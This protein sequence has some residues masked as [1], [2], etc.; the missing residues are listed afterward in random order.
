[1]LKP[2]VVASV[3]MIACKK[4]KK[5]SAANNK[6]FRLAQTSIPIRWAHGGNVLQHSNTVQYVSR[7]KDMASSKPITWTAAPHPNAL[8]FFQSTAITPGSPHLKHIAVHAHNFDERKAQGK[9][10]DG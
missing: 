3:P 10:E 4:N 2:T 8:F 7:K 1:M 9:K 6:N 5:C